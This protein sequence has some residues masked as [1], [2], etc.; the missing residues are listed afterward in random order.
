MATPYTSVTS[1]WIM[2]FL[3]HSCAMALRSH[4]LQDLPDG[5]RVLQLLLRQVVEQILGRFEHE[6]VEILAVAGLHRQAGRAHL[7]IAH[8]RAARSSIATATETMPAKESLRRSA[9]C[10][11]RSRGSAASHP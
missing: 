3:S 4:A 5:F 11:G 2:G 6:G 1:A 8:Q 9:A 10:V 7:R